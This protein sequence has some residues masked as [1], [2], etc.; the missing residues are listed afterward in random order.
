MQEV[1]NEIKAI[2]G[3]LEELNIPATIHNMDKL[4]GCQQHLAIVLELLKK[5]AEEEK[6]ADADTE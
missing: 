2:S 1:I 6:H 3:A 4:L 5:K